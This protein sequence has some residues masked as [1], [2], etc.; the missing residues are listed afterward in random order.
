MSNQILILEPAPC[1]R[2]T[3]E[4]QILRRESEQDRPYE[5]IARS[6]ILL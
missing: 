6:L 2:V 5:F 4:G 1:L 3:R